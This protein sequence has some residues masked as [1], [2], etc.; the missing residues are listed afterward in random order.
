MRQREN[1][2]VSENRAGN[3]V[4]VAS[5]GTPGKCDGRDRDDAGCVVCPTSHLRACARKEGRKDGIA[6]LIKNS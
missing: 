3:A 4:S 6:G 1:E 2:T 5:Q